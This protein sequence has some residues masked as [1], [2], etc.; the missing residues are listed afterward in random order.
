MEYTSLHK[1]NAVVGIGSMVDGY[2]VSV[3]IGFFVWELRKLGFGEYEEC[4]RYVSILCV[5]LEV[6]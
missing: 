6:N 3:C 5:H 2:I 4:M 1:T